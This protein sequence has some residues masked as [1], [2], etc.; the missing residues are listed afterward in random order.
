MAQEKRV[1]R[2]DERP[3]AW[4]FI[5]EDR[6]QEIEGTTEYPVMYRA[7]GTKPA[8]QHPFNLY[9]DILTEPTVLKATFEVVEDHVKKIAEE[10]VTREIDHVVQIG[11]GTSQ[12]IGQVVAPALWKYAGMSAEDFDSVEF[13]NYDQPYDIEHTAFFFY[14]GSG[15]TFDTI[16]A[17]KKVKELG[18][19]SLAFTSIA[20]SPLTKVTSATIACV[21]G[22]DTGG[23]DTFH[24]CTRLGASLRLALELGSL[25]FPDSPK[26]EWSKLKTQLLVVPDLMAQ[27]MEYIDKRSRSMAKMYKSMRSV[28]IVGSGPNIGTAEEMALKFEEMAHIP[29][30]AMVPTRHLHGA[31]GLT[32]EKILTVILAPETPSRKWLVQI[33]KVTQMLKTPS[34]GI[35]PENEHEIAD[36]MD[37]VVRVPFTDEYLFALFVVPA[38]QLFPYYCGVEQGDINPDCQ[39]SNIPKYARVWDMVLPPGGH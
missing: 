34:I 1:M 10:M 29:A 11:M 20:E 28:I 8:T 6:H 24:Y 22:F 14:S 23:S 3:A 4:S 35:I 37:Y 25:K 39:R 21:G 2:H 38:I 7:L 19:Y 26:F 36:M 9:K 15:S 18:G 17:A 32:D 27:R 33:A 30:K 13:L 31:L 16:S 12:F 5:K